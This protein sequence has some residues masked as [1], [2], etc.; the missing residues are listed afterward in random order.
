MKYGL[1][2]AILLT[3]CS[4]VVPVSQKF[5]DVPAV[6][7]E[8]CDVLIILNDGAKLSDIATSVT[9]NYTLYHKCSNRHDEFIEWYNNQKKIYESVK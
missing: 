8:K 9:N 7:S 4:T 5:P 2:L 3:G 6:L 1:I